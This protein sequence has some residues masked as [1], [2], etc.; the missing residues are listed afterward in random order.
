MVGFKYTYASDIWNMV[1]RKVAASHACRLH[2]PL[3]GPN[4]PP[5]ELSR[6]VE[7]SHLIF[8]SGPCVTYDSYKNTYLLGLHRPTSN[9][10][11]RDAIDPA[12]S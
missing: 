10:N 7:N 5:L 2:T 8:L 1:G 4:I 6:G 3:V 9:W 12:E 11:L